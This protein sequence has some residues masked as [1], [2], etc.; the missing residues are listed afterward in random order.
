MNI[1]DTTLALLKA[2]QWRQKVSP[3]KPLGE[4]EIRLLRILPANDSEP[5]KCSLIHYNLAAA[6]S[7]HVAISYP[8]GPP[9]D[10][11]H[12]CIVNGV[13]F[14]VRDNAFQILTRLR[15]PDEAVD[16]WLDC[17]CID[18]K[19]KP[20]KSA[21]IRLMYTIYQRARRTIIWLGHNPDTTGEVVAWIKS[22]DTEKIYREFCVSW[23]D[24][25]RYT[26]KSFI[27]DM[28]EGYPRKAFLINGVARL[29]FA[30]YF[31][32]VWIRQEAAVGGNPHVLWGRDELS[33]TQVAVLAWIYRPR[34]TI[35]WPLWIDFLYGELEFVTETILSIDGYRY[36]LI[37]LEERFSTTSIATPLYAQ[38]VYSRPG[39]T[40]KAHDKVYAL[41]GICSD[42][43][44]WTP[45]TGALLKPSYSL[46]WQ[47]VYVEAAKFF[48]NNRN[49]GE[50]QFLRAA[51]LQNQGAGSDL[52][53]W[54]PDW[55]YPTRTLLIDTDD[56]AAGGNKEH[57][58]TNISSLSKKQRS[59]LLA[60]EGYTSI[61]PLLAP[62]PRDKCKITSTEL[63]EV[64]EPKQLLPQDFTC[65]DPSCKDKISKA[66]YAYLQ[67][68]SRAAV[69]LDVQI[70]MQDQIIYL[71]RTS[72]W[73][74]DLELPDFRQEVLANDAENLRFLDSQTAA[75]RDLYITDEPFRTAYYTTLIA[76]QDASS[77]RATAELVAS[78]DEWRVWLADDSI[79][80]LATRSN[81][82]YHG[83]LETMFSFREYLF[84]YTNSGYMCLVPHFTK[85]G[86]KVTVVNGYTVPFVVRPTVQDWHM[87][88]G[89]CYVHGM[90]TD[91]ASE[92]MEEFQIKFDEKAGQTAVKR[93]QGDV[94]ANGL[95]MEAGRYID[96]LGTLGKRW[97]E[98]I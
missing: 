83:A 51:G 44:P 1:R 46:S 21:Q 5:L 94:R 28:L 23:Q 71:G 66:E 73:R 79:D 47:E 32:R 12:P 42:I 90:M 39:L 13:E 26:N 75:G 11:H 34:V 3:Y 97:M 15:Q 27:L 4:N 2:R 38:M 61:G 18:Q 67:S 95:K 24:F 50:W 91:K 52:P 65:E 62:L 22:L 53:S 9:E 49:L 60:F 68:A 10:P 85:L 35:D 55:R 6:E 76:C 69:A 98:L 78:A 84:A 96:I 7:T 70:S 33:W 59:Q 80:H 25:S 48:T 88:I 14:T 87:L 20:E 82:P 16:V 89:V 36:R 31:T 29:F 43:Q 57:V 40:T 92:L 54:V 56:W 74:H 37:P 17:L 93:P 72:D 8:W 86:D 81:V 45:N 41:T 30:V 64:L 77:R 19:N 63:Y 58:R